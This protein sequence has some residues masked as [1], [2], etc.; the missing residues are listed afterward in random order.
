MAVVAAAVTVATTAT[1]LSSTTDD[2]ASGHAVL[3]KVPTGGATVY[4]GGAGVTTGAGFPV[5]A[6]EAVAFDLTPGDVLYGIVAADT[7]A[8]NVIR[9]G[10]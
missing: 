7:Q 3:V 10:V 6:A 1:Q 4:V 9:T 5:A 2:Y 8:V